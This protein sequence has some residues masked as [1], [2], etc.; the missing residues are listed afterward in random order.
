MTKHLSGISLE[1]A[2]H[3]LFDELQLKY[4]VRN[5]VLLITAPVEA[6][7]DEY[8]TTKFY[9]VKDLILVRSENDEIETEF[10]PLIDLIQNSVAT[11][12]WLENGG[13]GSITPY[14]FQDRCL[15]A[16]SQPQEVHEE[17][18]ALLTALR[19]CAAPDAKGGNEL[20][21]PRRPKIVPPTFY[22][23]P[24]DPPP[25]GPGGGFF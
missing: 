4:V 24:G 7:R 17:I 10:R 18:A 15:L 12:T 21:L 23:P 19:R 13:R 22:G 2:L 16:I 6:E 3:L 14:Q 5:E 9:P 20:R 11:T 8:M 1:S 25:Y